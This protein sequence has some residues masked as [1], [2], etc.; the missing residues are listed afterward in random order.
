[1]TE[2]RAHR[3]HS[4]A[5]FER[6]T[7][8]AGRCRIWSATTCSTDRCDQWLDQREG[9]TGRMFHEIDLRFGKSPTK[10]VKQ[11]RAKE[12]ADLP[13]ELAR[14]ELPRRRRGKPWQ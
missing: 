4:C 13:P 8:A 9:R 2:Q 1:M 3:C 11:I 5:F 14:T 12:R 6:R 7:P 10:I